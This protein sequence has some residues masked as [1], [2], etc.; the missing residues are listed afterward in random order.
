MQTWQIAALE[1]EAAGLKHL[2]GFIHAH[3]LG[4]FIGAIG[5]L[6]A[7]LAWVLSGALRR[8]GGNFHVRP[9]VFIPLPGPPPPPP[10]TFN[11]FP[12]PHYTAHDN[13]RD[14]YEE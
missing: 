1:L 6:L 2:D 3:A 9:V 4:F 14:D 13:H 11:P 7:L 12:P 5:L 8:K 10:E